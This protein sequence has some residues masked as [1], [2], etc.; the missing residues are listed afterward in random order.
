MH[1]NQIHFMII[2]KFQKIKKHA[3]FNMTMILNNHKKM[4]NNNYCHKICCSD[5]WIN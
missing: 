2:Y 3:F 1:Y 4:Y 5:H